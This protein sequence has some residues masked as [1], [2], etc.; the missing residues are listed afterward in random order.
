MNF[1]FCFSKEDLLARNRENRKKTE[2]EFVY[3]RKIDDELRRTKFFT[4]KQIG[5][6]ESQKDEQLKLIYSL[7]QE[8]DA[9]KDDVLEKNAKI[10]ELEDTIQKLV[11]ENNKMKFELENIST[12]Q[13]K[14]QQNYENEQKGHQITKRDLAQLKEE[15]SSTFFSF[16]NFQ[17]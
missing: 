4:E 2:D 9:L 16:Q 10:K 8:R 5:D 3:S 15:K 6:L 7:K 11:G 1:D 13:A 14:Y 12:Q 17:N